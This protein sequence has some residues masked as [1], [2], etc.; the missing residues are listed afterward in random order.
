MTTAPKVNEFKLG[1]RP[2]ANAETLE[3]MRK[4]LAGGS[5]S[6]ML[7]RQ[8]PRRRRVGT[9]SFLWVLLATG[10][11]AGL[12]V[13]A[14]SYKEEILEVIGMQTL[15]SPLAPSAALERDDLARFWAFA[16]FDETKLRARFTI[17]RNAVVDPVDARHHLEDILSKNLVGDAARAEIASLRN[18]ADQANGSGREA[19]RTVR[20]AQ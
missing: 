17:S 7:P 1:Q 15:T 4:K 3:K 12:N 18:A 2:K 19:I 10:V 13:F 6:A 16:A 5:E 20:A 11:V 14:R 9:K 8:P